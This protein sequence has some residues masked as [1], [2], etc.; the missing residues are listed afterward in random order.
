MTKEQFRREKLYQITLAI[1]RSMF[2]RGLI[3]AGELCEIE[4]VML[5]KYR[6]LLGSLYAKN[7]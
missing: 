7:P 4:T 2:R 6:P 3:T 1:A 5:T